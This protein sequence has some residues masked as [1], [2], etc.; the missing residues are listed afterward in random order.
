MRNRIRIA[1][2]SLTLRYY[3]ST[4]VVLL[5][6]GGISVYEKRHSCND[7]AVGKKDKASAEASGTDRRQ[8]NER[9]IIR[10]SSERRIYRSRSN[11]WRGCDSNPLSL[12]LTPPPLS[13]LP[14]PPSATSPSFAPTLR[15]HRNSPPHCCSNVLSVPLYLTFAIFLNSRKIIIRRA[16]HRL[17]LSV[18]SLPFF[19]GKISNRKL[20]SVRWRRRV[21]QFL[22]SRALRQTT[23][24]CAKS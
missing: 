24:N 22:F 14:L 3:I 7:S 18:T 6:L 12:G 20:T 2:S 13:S 8:T 17:R 15:F 10:R 21:W 19:P 9:N 1:R 4:F 23:F 5:V 11:G 16:R